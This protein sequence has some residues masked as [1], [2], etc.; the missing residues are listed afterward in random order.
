[1]QSTVTRKL[2]LPVFSDISVV[3]VVVERSVRHR[4]DEIDTERI[5]E[6]SK[7]IPAFGVAT[8]FFNVTLIEY[9]NF[10]EHEFYFDEVFF[11]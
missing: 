5:P 3:N 2:F 11:I 10:F 8:P 6:R 7:R 1:M 4:L 9:K